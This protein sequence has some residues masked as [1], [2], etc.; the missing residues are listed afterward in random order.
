MTDTQNPTLYHDSK[1]PEPI[2]AGNR[3]GL[4]LTGQAVFGNG[5][6]TGAIQEIDYTS[7]GVLLGL[8]YRLTDEFT[9][10]F[11]TGYN[12]NNATLDRLSSDLTVE[13]Y[14]VGFYG[15][16]FNGKGWHVDASAIYTYNTYNSTRN[17]SFA[18]INRRAQGDT[19]G[20]Q[21]TATLGA[22]YDFKVGRWT[23]QPEVGTQL[24]YL[25]VDPYAETGAGA[26]NLRFQQQDAYSL[27]THVG[28]AIR[29]EAKVFKT[30]VV[31]ELR[32]AWHHEFLDNSR[33]VNIGFNEAALGS[34]QAKTNTPE[35]DFALLGAGVTTYFSELVSAYLNY[36]TQVGQDS[37]LAH[38]VNG[39]VRFE[40]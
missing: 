23:F 38:G 32:G 33:G 4:F 37:F 8:D 6:P 40:F 14:P 17:I 3:W 13:S 34:F 29:Y 27:R 12:Q 25:S 30:L 1:N 18:T 16:W 36:D 5:S 35:R 10:G 28:G 21:A 2:Q 9:L 22:G 7:A 31:P 11:V 24:T 20:H 19:D 15:S 26:L 39:G